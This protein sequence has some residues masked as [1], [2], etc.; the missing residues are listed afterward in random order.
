MQRT[1]A[2]HSDATQDGTSD[3]HLAE[4]VVECDPSIGS[5][6]R[7]KNSPPIGN[8]R[9]QRLFAHDMGPERQRLKARIDVMLRRRRHHHHVRLDRLEHRL[10]PLEE[11]HAPPR[12]RAGAA[13]RV[14]IARA[15]ERG[16]RD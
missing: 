8:R 5:S 7:S 15:D 3:A 11:R 1:D 9:C 2:G 4:L 10:E 6:G 16:I 13:L 14:Q 12:L